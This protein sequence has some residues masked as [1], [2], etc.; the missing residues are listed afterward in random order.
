MS[1]FDKLKVYFYNHKLYKFIDCFDENSNIT[2]RNIIDDYSFDEI[3]IDYNS[4]YS[5]V[6]LNYKVIG[7]FRSKDIIDFY[8]IDD[9]LILLKLYSNQFIDIKITDLLIYGVDV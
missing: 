7:L 6:I 5:P 9:L 3:D 2:F 8:D 4:K 1:Y